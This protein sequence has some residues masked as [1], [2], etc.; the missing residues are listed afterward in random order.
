MLALCACRTSCLRIGSACDSMKL[1]RG[2]SGETAAVTL[3]IF[4]FLTVMVT[5]IGPQRSCCVTGPL[6]L[7]DEAARAGEEERTPPVARAAKVSGS[8]RC[9]SEAWVMKLSFLCCCGT[10][11]RQMLPPWRLATAHAWRSVHAAC[12]RR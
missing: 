6:Y 11:T 4:L 12:R 10:Y 7:A 3:V 8:A 9:L 2:L 1:E 5:W